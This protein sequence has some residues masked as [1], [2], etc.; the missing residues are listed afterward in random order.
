MISN[1]NPNTAANCTLQLWGLTVPGLN[2]NYA[3][4]PN[5]WTIAST[6]GA[7]NLQTGYATLQCSTSV[8]AQLLYSYYSAGGTKLGEATVFSSPPARSVQILADNRDGAQL[9]LAIANDS[10]QTNTYTIAAGN[11]SGSVTLAPR[12]S[13]AK[14]VN[15][16]LTLPP[17]YMGPVIISSGTGTASIIGL[18]YTGTVFTTIPETIRP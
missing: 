13:T 15:Q 4:G 18:R 11:S 8:E 3:L 16:F 10:D 2:L 1:P 14:F 17:N 6:A 12:S 7:Q 9:G 5:G